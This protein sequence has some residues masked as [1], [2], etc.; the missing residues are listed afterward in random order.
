MPRGF[1]D[2]FL[3]CFALFDIQFGFKDVQYTFRD[4]AKHNSG[5]F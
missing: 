2:L 1:Y 5:D 3:A 4:E